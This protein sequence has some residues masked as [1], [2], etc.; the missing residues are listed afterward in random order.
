M[1]GMYINN[2]V[3]FGKELMGRIHRDE[4]PSL[5]AELAY[6]LLLSLFP[7]LIFLI[8]LIG[9]LPLEST[10][11]LDL[12]ENVAPQQTLHMIESNVSHIIGSHNEKLL[13][14]GI[15][16]TM[17][18]ASNGINAIVRAFNRAYHVQ[19][20]RPFL[21]AR[22]MA[23]LLTFAMIFVIIVALLLPVFEIGRAHV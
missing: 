20:N 22:G 23:V 4:L 9:F 2:I 16:A 6:Y 17:W 8:T 1:A 7:F 18:S 19:E 12:V 3:R 11:L 13:S 14:F 10:D 15:I 5:S 21:V